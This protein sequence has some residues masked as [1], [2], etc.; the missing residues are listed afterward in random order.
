MLYLRLNGCGKVG[1]KTGC[2]SG[3]KEEYCSLEE[4]GGREQSIIWVCDA[5]EGVSGSR[6]RGFSGDALVVVEYKQGE[7]SIGG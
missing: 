3:Q 6:S 1:S 4:I 2:S 7:G 5:G